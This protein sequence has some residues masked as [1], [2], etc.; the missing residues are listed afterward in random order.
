MGI[1]TGLLSRKE[2]RKG[3][4][5][6][7][8][9][10]NRLLGQAYETARLTAANAEIDRLRNKLGEEVRNGTTLALDLAEARKLADSRAEK[11][12]ALNN[13]N[14]ALRAD[15]TAWRDRQRKARDYEKN[16]RVRPKVAG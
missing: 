13:E 2:H 3:A 14:A 9:E 10:Q 12:R 16:R 1:F 8:A 15:A 11:I 6:R 7:A 5:I 4:D